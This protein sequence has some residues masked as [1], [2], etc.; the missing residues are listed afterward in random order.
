MLAQ[1]QVAGERLVQETERLLEFSLHEQVFIERI[2]QLFQDP[3]EGL[4]T[5][6]HFGHA[7]QLLQRHLQVP[8]GPVGHPINQG[9]LAVFGPG[10]RISVTADQTQESRR[11]A[12]EVL[13]LGGRPIREPVVQYGP[14]VMNSKAELIQAMDDFQAGKFGAIPPNALMPHRP[15]R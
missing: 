5:D 6:L 14:F 13:I 11:P 4:G 12:L 9:Q 10:D 8:V 15:L 7:D 1:L 3:L 2:E